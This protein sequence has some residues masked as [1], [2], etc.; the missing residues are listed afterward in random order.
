MFF[1]DMDIVLVEGWKES[2]LPKVLVSGAVT[3]PHG[4]KNIIAEIG[5]R[6]TVPHVPLFSPAAI[7][8]LA[9]FIVSFSPLS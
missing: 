2:S 3:P 1:K 7:A 5:K 4:I 6:G 9:D 8:A